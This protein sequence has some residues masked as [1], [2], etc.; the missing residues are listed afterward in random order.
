MWP[1]TRKRPTPSGWSVT[2]TPSLT[3]PQQPG[4]MQTASWRCSTTPRPTMYTAITSTASI[5]WRALRPPATA[6]LLWSA[7]IRSL[8]PTTQA[9]SG[10]PPM[11]CCRCGFFVSTAALTGWS[12]CGIPTH[13]SGDISAIPRR[14]ATSMSTPTCPRARSTPRPSKTCCLPRWLICSSC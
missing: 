3:L 4:P 10:L 5:F 6:P 14:G 1:T 2:M 12:M 7:A 9:C 11:L 8:P 13:T